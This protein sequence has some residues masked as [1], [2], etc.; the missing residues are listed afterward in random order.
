MNLLYTKTFLIYDCLRQEK[1]KTDK[2]IRSIY[3]AL[4][5]RTLSTCATFLISFIVTH[6]IGFAV[7]ISFIEVLFKILLYYLHERFW[8]RLNIGRHQE[9]LP[10]SQNEH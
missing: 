8:Q 6:S 5:W 3:K 10:D 1:M 7:S 2:R 9:M 4:S